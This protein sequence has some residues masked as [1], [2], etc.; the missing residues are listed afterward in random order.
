MEIS[1]IYDGQF[2]GNVFVVGK[3]GCGKTTFLQKL[4][5]NNFFGK[6]L[7]T[8]WIS[9]IDID[10]ER[11][12]EIQSCFENEVEIHIAIEPD[13]LD[14]LLETF[15][16]RTF[17]LAGDDVGVNNSLFG[18]NKK[19]D[20]LIVMDDISGVADTSKK[21]VNFLT[22]S[23]KFRYHCIYLFHVIAPATQI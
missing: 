13:E 16:L 9:G 21:F 5:I 6:I 15:K 18:G 11:E 17:D 10:K 22:V 3:T 1:S 7:K 8:E 2:R 23:R 12:A 20:R 4:G 14:S 19:M